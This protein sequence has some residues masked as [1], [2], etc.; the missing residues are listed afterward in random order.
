M[1][2]SFVIGICIVALAVVGFLATIQAAVTVLNPNHDLALELECNY[3]YQ[4]LGG[5]YDDHMLVWSGN[6]DPA[7]L[8][9]AIE[10]VYNG[11][12]PTAARDALIAANKR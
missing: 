11:G 8:H 2:K 5:K 9:A 7:H 10:A 3:D 6:T 1:F 12:N 4:P